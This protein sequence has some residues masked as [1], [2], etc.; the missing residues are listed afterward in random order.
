MDYTKPHN[1]GFTLVELIVT[2]VLI[3]TLAA[4]AIPRMFDATAFRDRGFFDEVV[5]AARYGQKLAVASGC[6]VE[7]SITS[8]TGI[9]GGFALHQRAGSCTAGAFTRKVLRPADSDFFEASAPPGVALSTTATPIIF[10]SLGRASGNF[11]VTVGD[12]S[13]TIAADSGYVGGL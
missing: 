1:R 9:D 6:D 12:R 4:V 2:M 11:I 7:L 8:G 5:N 13:F 3:G 10:D